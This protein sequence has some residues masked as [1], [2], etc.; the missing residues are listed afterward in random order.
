MNARRL[1]G[2]PCGL[3]ANCGDSNAALYDPESEFARFFADC[4]AIDPH[5]FHQGCFIL[6]RADCCT[7][8][9]DS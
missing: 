4:S 2:N 7:P 8:M 1:S 6:R 9:T 3:L 5:L